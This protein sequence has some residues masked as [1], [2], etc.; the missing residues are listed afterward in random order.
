[1]DLICFENVENDTLNEFGHA[2]YVM[3]WVVFSLGIPVT[4]LAICLLYCLIC[5]N[6]VAPIFIINLLISDLLQMCVIPLSLK[7]YCHFVVSLGY[8][9]GLTTSVCFMVCIALERYLVVV[10][11]LWYR[12]RCKVKYCVI[13]SSIIWLFP[14]V[15]IGIESY[16]L[17]GEASLIL[18][19]VLILIPLPLL[20]F[21]VGTLR[22]LSVS[23]S[24]PLL[25]K[26]RIIGVLVLVLGIYCLLFLPRVIFFLLVAMH[27]PVATPLG[28]FLVLLNPLVDPLLYVFIRRGACPCSCLDR[29]L[30]GEHNLT[31]TTTSVT[32]NPT[33][34]TVTGTL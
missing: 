12:F 20:I 32:N 21:L 1:M 14:F 28:G 5:A 18:T 16:L 26:I 10:F 2:V 33:L 15:K 31:Q 13:V 6:H 29:L 30:P 3:G 23:I 11:P 4:F 9:I 19:S 25:E 8:Y 27:S 22:A 34:T 7:G 24:V 17:S